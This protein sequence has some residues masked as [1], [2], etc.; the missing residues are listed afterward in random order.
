MGKRKRPE[1]R[2][3]TTT[4]ATPDAEERETVKP[5]DETR[6]APRGTIC[7]LSDGEQCTKD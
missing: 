5:S 6:K 2:D 3:V 4:V 7:G 1:G